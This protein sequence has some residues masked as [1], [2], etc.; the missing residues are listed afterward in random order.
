MI[1]VRSETPVHAPTLSF[2]TVQGMQQ[3]LVLE[4][5]QVPLGLVRRVMHHTGALS[6]VL[7]RTREPVGVAFNSNGT[8]DQE[9]SPDP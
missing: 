3:R 2:G 6:A 7:G 9:Y 4:E 8:L 5:I 1:D